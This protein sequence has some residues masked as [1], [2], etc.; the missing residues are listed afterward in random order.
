MKKK[1]DKDEKKSISSVE[2]LQKIIEE[3]KKNPGKE[4][5]SKKVPLIKNYIPSKNAIIDGMEVSNFQN[6][7]FPTFDSIIAMINALIKRGMIPLYVIFDESFPYLLNEQDYDRFNRALKDGINIGQRKIEIVL[8]K[9]PDDTIKT[10]VN[11]ALEYNAKIVVNQDVLDS[12]EELTQKYPKQFKR[13]LW[14]IK[15][16]ITEGKIQFIV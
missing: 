3:S 8:T 15:Y 4:L 1:S 6:P 9:N 7:G 2:S 13:Q 12:Y 11:Y 5:N 16:S 10:L 14:Q